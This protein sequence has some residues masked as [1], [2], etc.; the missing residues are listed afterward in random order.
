M[1]G[2]QFDELAGIDENGSKKVQLEP[3]NPKSS[4]VASRLQFPKSYGRDL[5]RDECLSCLVW[6]LGIRIMIIIYLFII[7]VIN[8]TIVINIIII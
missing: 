8:I 5:L 7:I 2:F 6:S 1:L 3:K 4:D